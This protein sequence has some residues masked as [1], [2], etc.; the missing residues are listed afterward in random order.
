MINYNAVC[1]AVSLPCYIVESDPLSLFSGP[2]TYTFDGADVS[3]PSSG[4]VSSTVRL[5]AVSAAVFAPTRRDIYMDAS[6][7]N[8]TYTKALITSTEN[9]SRVVLAS[10]VKKLAGSNPSIVTHIL[11]KAALAISPDVP[12]ST[13]DVFD[14]LS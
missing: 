12:S 1:A 7:V 4:Q 8:V 6:L 11:A 10:D 3:I 2:I 14:G 13:R 5:E 9:G